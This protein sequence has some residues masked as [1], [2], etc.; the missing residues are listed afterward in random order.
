MC[1]NARSGSGLPCGSWQCSKFGNC[2]GLLA[3]RATPEA[4]IIGLNREV[5]AV[6]ATSEINDTFAAR[7]ASPAGGSPEEFAGSIKADFEFCK[8]FSER[9]GLKVE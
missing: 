1:S 4:I 5:N 3:P 6:L 7:F 8:R 9:T 2:Y